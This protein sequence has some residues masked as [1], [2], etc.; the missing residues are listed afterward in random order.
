MP[1]SQTNQTVAKP[2]QVTELAGAFSAFNDLSEQ[3]LLAYSALENRVAL[4]TEELAA[5]RSERLNQLA[6]KERLA[7]RLQQ[8]IDALPAAVIVVDGEG[9]VRECNGVA[10][11]LLAESLLDRPWRDVAAR[12][13]TQA[14]EEPGEWIVGTRR[15]SL[16]VSQ[17]NG[18]PGQ[19]I[20]L[21]DVTET[22]R[23]QHSLDRH[24]RLSAMGEMVAS[25]AHQLRTPLATALLQVSQLRG[26]RLQAGDRDAV[27]GKLTSRLRHLDTMVNDMLGFAR[28]S[29]LALARVATDEL[30]HDL[31]GGMEHVLNDRQAKLIIEDPLLSTLIACNKDV[32]LGALQNL[33]T[34]AMDAGGPGVTV[35]INV[36]A[37]GDEVV[38][39][40]AD[41]GPGIRAD[42]KERVFEPFFTTRANGTGLGLAV[43]RSVVL[44]HG[45]SIDFA[46]ESDRGT[47]FEIRLPAFRDDSLLVSGH[48]AA[49]AMGLNKKEV[50]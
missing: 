27:L 9:I 33:V 12:A 17:L 32:M 29:D 1:R 3:L 40:V 2:T 42:V 16:S 18:E 6:E 7:L 46:S 31:A 4:L 24:R 37:D 23:L 26:E 48:S 21:Q 43:V 22:R 39:R 50:V 41:D 35:R 36:V 14:P 38:I 10:Q 34:N 5:A 15:V 19:I 25:I 8:L 49:S 11:T 47:E 13:L 44:A 30:I 45:G 20:L 28:G